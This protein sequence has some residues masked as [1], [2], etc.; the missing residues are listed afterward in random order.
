MILLTQRLVAAEGY[1]E[2]RECLDRRWASVFRA[3]G[4]L[5]VPTLTLAPVDSYFE[6]PIAGVVVTGGNDLSDVS[7]DPLSTDRDRFELA[8]VAEA[9]RRGVPV[10]GVCRGLQLLTS[11]AGYALMRVRGHVR[12]RHSLNVSKDSPRAAQIAACGEV[13]S[14]HGWAVPAVEVRHPWRA[15]A[16]CDDGT[17]EAL[18]HVSEP[19]LGLGWHP[20]REEPLREAEL[21]L[22]ATFLMGARR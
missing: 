5:P 16:W 4:A 2:V 7:A 22:L 11:V 8:L 3:I 18:E 1:P 21:D 9:R 17:V 20:E 12:T 19:I 14:Y 10:L 13:N 6:L 15:A